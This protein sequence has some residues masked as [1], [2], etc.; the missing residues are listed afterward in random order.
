MNIKMKRTEEE[1]AQSFGTL[2]SRI[3]RMRGFL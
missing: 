2:V 1:I 3:E